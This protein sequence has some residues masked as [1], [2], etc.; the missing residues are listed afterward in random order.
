MVFDKTGKEYY[1]IAEALLKKYYKEESDYILVNNF[2]GN[3]LK[4]IYYKPLFEYINQS[5]ISDEYKS[6]YFQIIS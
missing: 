3:D 4:N 1:I 5:N 2:E 6:K